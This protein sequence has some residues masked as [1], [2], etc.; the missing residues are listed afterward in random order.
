MDSSYPGSK[1]LDLQGT[2][3]NEVPTRAILVFATD[4]A[5]YTVV[6]AQTA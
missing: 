4:I 5:M 6:C 3:S 2:P 1:L